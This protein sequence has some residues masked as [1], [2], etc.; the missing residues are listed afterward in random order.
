MPQ[1][2]RNFGLP[3]QLESL[4]PLRRELLALQHCEPQWHLPCP[5]GGEAL[6]LFIDGSC[7]HSREPPLAI[8]AW[9]VVSA[10]H[11]ACVAAAG[12]PG[13]LQTIPR[14]EAWALLISLRWGRSYPGTI[15]IWSDS[16]GTVEGFRALQAHGE[17]DKKG[18]LADVWHLI[19]RAYGECEGEIYI[20]KVASHS[21]LGHAQSPLEE[22]CIQ[23]NHAADRAATAANENRPLQFQQTYETF[24]TEWRTQKALLT[25][26]IDLHLAIAEADFEQPTNPNV[27]AYPDEQDDFIE[28]ADVLPWYNECTDNSSLTWLTDLSSRTGTAF[29]VYD[30]LHQWLC[31]LENDSDFVGYVTILEFYVAYCMHCQSTFHEVL[32]HG[33]NPYLQLTLAA[34]YALFRK[35]FYQLLNSIEGRPAYIRGTLKNCGIT[36]GLNGLHFAWKRERG[37]GIHGRLRDFVGNRPIRNHQGF[38]RPWRLR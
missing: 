21:V 27:N 12:L 11:G 36:C 29:H 30:H 22:W 20:H 4:W 31:D 15:H 38:S 19:S 24:T 1:A 26:L 17:Y 28:A 9:S 33:R 35:C 5:R 37:V 2:M 16:L 6:H 8:A 18:A 10:S 7:F 14:A 34:D 32:G 23:W 13:L 3:G 25:E